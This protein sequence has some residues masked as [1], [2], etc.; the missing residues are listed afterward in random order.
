MLMHDIIFKENIYSD[1]DRIY[2]IF[3]GT[4]YNKNGYF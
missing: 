1:S 3:C 4:L 2:K